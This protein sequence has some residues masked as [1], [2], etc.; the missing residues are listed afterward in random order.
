MTAG[1]N[2]IAIRELRAVDARAS[3]W[4]EVAVMTATGTSATDVDWST[5][6][7]DSARDGIESWLGSL[8][9]DTL[10]PKSPDAWT[11]FDV[12]G[13]DD[14]RLAFHAR[15]RSADARGHRRWPS[16]VIAEPEPIPEPPVRGR[17]LGLSLLPFH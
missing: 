9:P 12:P 3:F 5:L 14:V 1:L 17:D 11:T 8:H 4:V 13:R 10:D 2:E 6:D 16:L 7:W 15:P